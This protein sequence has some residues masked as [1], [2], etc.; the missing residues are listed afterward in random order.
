[1][2]KKKRLYERQCSP[3]MLKSFHG[4]DSTCFFKEKHCMKTIFKGK[5]KEKTVNKTAADLPFAKHPVN[6]TVCR[7]VD[8]VT[9]ALMTMRNHCLNHVNPMANE[10]WNA[11][12]KPVQ[13]LCSFQKQK[14]N[15]ENCN[16]LRLISGLPLV[17]RT[18]ARSERS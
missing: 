13:N 10:I 12:K 17:Y 15:R 14:K 7:V 5:K 18:A 16:L 3:K 8:L 2:N 11:I 6:L 4:S 9:A 1:M